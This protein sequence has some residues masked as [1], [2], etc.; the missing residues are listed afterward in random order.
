M[1]QRTPRISNSYQP[2]K[3]VIQGGLGNQLFTFSAGYAIAANSGR[4]A[5]MRL[6]D[7]WYRSHAVRRL[8]GFDARRFELHRFPEIRNQFPLLQSIKQMGLLV[9]TRVDYHLGNSGGDVVKDMHEPLSRSIQESA[10][11][12][13]GY[14]R[15]NRLFAPFRSDLLRLLR[16]DARESHT[17]AEIE[18]D[19]RRNAFDLV[20]IHV[21]R[22]DLVGSFSNRSILPTEYFQQMM[23]EV[24]TPKSR[25][26]VFTDSPEWCR[27]I[28]TFKDAVI[29]DSDDPVHSMFLISRCDSIIMSRSTLSYWSAWLSDPSRTQVYAPSPFLQAPGFDWERNLLP[30]WKRFTVPVTVD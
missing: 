23:S 11:V 27:G 3:V 21:R 25:F 18:K 17:L 29:M 19:L 1:S 15:D 2:L 13:N 10:R 12:V 4:L 9:K 8:K 24:W 5:Q 20:A 30:Q 14:F 28:S 6:A 26:V 7:F 16:L 22:G